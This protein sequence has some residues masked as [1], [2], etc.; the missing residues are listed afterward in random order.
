MIYSDQMIDFARGGHSCA[1]DRALALSNLPAMDVRS[2]PGWRAVRSGAQAND[3][4]VVISSPGYV[5]EADVLS[6]LGR[7]FGPAPASWLVADADPR[8]TEVLEAAG[9]VSERTARC[10]GRSLSE[11]PAA[12]QRAAVEVVHATG[13]HAEEWL[14]IAQRCGWYDSDDERA[15]R[16]AIL[17]SAASDPRQVALVARVAQEPVGMVR[18]WLSAPWVEIVDV[19]VLPSLRREG[20]GTT[21]V[22]R[23]LAWGLD[24]GA[25]AAV[26]SPSPDGWQLLQAL[27]FEN[28]PVVPDTW[29]YSPI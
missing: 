2:A 1:L 27:A 13:K 22:N 17:E 15:T 5:P 19:A 28:V 21:L 9:R 14:D 3:L 18:G 23:V 4:N 12:D 7:W 16:R 11:S 25:R 29:F 24:G 10:C 20:I 8:L 26:A 6:E